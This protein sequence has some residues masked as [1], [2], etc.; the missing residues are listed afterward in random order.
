MSEL[1]PYMKTLDNV[2]L[3]QVATELEGEGATARG[4]NPQRLSER[5][6]VLNPA[7]EALRLQTIQMFMSRMRESRLVAQD[8]VRNLQNRVEYALSAHH[9]H[10][11]LLTHIFSQSHS[12]SQLL[13][14]S[15]F[16]FEISI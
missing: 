13:I 7:T 3:R 2:L 11:L 1:S 6:A 15:F 4:R 9:S 12:L 14:F 10:M 16:F 8:K 5:L